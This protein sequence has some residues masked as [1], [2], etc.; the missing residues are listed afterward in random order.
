MY[1]RH[2]FS[3]I[4]FP[5]LFPTHLPWSFDSASCGRAMCGLL[6]TR[7]HAALSDGRPPAATATL[8]S[9]R[10]PSSAEGCACLGSAS[11]AYVDE[12]TGPAERTAFCRGVK[13]ILKP[14]NRLLPGTA[15]S[16]GFSFYREFLLSSCSVFILIP[17]RDVL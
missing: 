2:T 3:T 5:S 16:L 12:M 6:A 15:A 11:L 13:G 4:L 17:N 14:D 8:H 1:L 9:A 10:I 7:W